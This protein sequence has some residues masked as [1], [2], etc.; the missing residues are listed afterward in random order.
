[1]CAVM[2]LISGQVDAGEIRL[3]MAASLKDALWELCDVFARGNPGI[4]FQKN[5]GASGALAKQI[6][7]GAPSDIFFSANLE[8][9]DYLEEKGLVEKKNVNIL[10]YNKLVF[11]GSP[12]LNVKTMNGLVSLRKI[13]VGS[14]KSA[15]A[16]E[17]AIA[18]LSK[19]GIIKQLDKKLVMAKDVRECIMYAERGEVDGAF[20]YMTDASDI[21]DKVKMLFEVPRELY[22]RVTYPMGLTNAGA[23]N[24]EAKRFFK[25]LQSETAKAVLSRYGFMI[26]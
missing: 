21:S 9:M 14:P 1:M 4:T 12:N 18:A 6:E 11:I 26:E 24:D 15:P 5:S 2:V 17:Y 19:A 16:G 13:A 10:A 8:W 25:Y 22:P 20:V 3:S 23:G 7:S